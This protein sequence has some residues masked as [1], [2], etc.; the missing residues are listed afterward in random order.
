M[1]INDDKMISQNELATLLQ[2]IGV[3]DVTSN[4]I[5]AIMEQLG[6]G[7]AG[8]KQIHVQD[9]EEMILRGAQFLKV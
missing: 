6:E 2:S 7:E 1:D 4:D 8:N 5:S 3:K 9:V